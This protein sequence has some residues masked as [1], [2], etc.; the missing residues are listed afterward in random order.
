MSKLFQPEWVTV[1]D[2][3]GHFSRNAGRTISEK[4]VL[5]KALAEA[6]RGSGR[7]TLSVKFKTPAEGLRGK[8][9]P[10]GQAQLVPYPPLLA[11]KQRLEIRIEERVT[12]PRNAADELG[13][14]LSD[15][16]W[17]LLI[18]VTKCLKSDDKSTCALLSNFGVCPAQSEYEK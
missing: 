18:L 12:G 11:E 14:D 7:L 4:E 13:R 9:V 16:F 3:A 1:A 10:L 17:I 2:A 6:D 8:R 15:T 5:E